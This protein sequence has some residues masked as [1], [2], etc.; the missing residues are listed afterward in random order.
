MMAAGVFKLMSVHLFKT[1]WNVA[2]S[3]SVK[4]AELEDNT[5][6][7]EGILDGIDIIEVGF[8]VK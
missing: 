3:G 7:S 1:S 5:A 6:F 4:I 2:S 8:A